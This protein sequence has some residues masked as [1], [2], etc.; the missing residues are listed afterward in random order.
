MMMLPPQGLQP[1]GIPFEGRG[2]GGVGPKGYPGPG[3]GQF[4]GPSGIP[5]GMMG[6]L[7]HALAMM[8]QRRQGIPPIAGVT[9]S[10][11]Q[12][13]FNPRMAMP[14]QQMMPN[15]GFPPGPQVGGAE[16]FRAPPRLFAGQPFTQ[17]M[18]RGIQTTPN[19][20]SKIPY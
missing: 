7:R 3:L 11:Q 13:P 17:P 19:N 4:G 15:P 12:M 8:K 10:G 16:N 20:P 9:P 5:G 14:P 1:S 2:L 6:A 18:P